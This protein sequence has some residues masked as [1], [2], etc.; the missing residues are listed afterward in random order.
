MN[1]MNVG[2]ECFNNKIGIYDWNGINQGQ[3]IFENSVDD[4]S[5]Y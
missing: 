4:K 1:D 5:K 3:V 2:Y